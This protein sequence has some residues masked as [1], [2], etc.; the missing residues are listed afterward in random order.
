MSLLF[1]LLQ[2]QVE[3]EEANPV[4]VEACECI[5]VALTSLVPTPEHRAHLLI[6]LLSDSGNNSLTSYYCCCYY[7]STTTG[8]S[9][10]LSK[11]CVIKLQSHSFFN[12]LIHC[13][14]SFASQET[15]SEISSSQAILS[16]CCNTSPCI[17]TSNQ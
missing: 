7:Y 3:N 1:R 8:T 10:S 9:V 4:Q 11:I 2:L 15:S 13:N 17:T 14:N 6:S 16:S 5:A 12:R